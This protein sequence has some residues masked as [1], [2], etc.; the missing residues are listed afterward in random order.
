M[1]IFLSFSFSQIGSSLNHRGRL[2]CGY[3]LVVQASIPGPSSPAAAPPVRQHSTLHQSRSHKSQE[4][5]KSHRMVTQLSSPQEYKDQRTTLTFPFLTK[6]RPEISFSLV[7]NSIS[8]I[9]IYNIGVFYS[10]HFPSLN[11]S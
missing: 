3:S 11:L 10:L 9:N 1:A 8:I 4:N 6:S 2:P 7:G 5:P